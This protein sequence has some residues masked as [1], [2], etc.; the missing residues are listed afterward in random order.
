MVL[1]NEWIED[2]FDMVF[3]GVQVFL[4]TDHL[5]KAD[6]VLV[7]SLFQLLFQFGVLCS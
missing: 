6:L 5:V 4:D 3:Q 1:T 7:S 2:I